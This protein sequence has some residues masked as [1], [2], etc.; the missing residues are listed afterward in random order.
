MSLT[1]VSAR[2]TI[3]LLCARILADPL[4]NG[5]SRLTHPDRRLSSRTRVGEC[6]NSPVLLNGTTLLRSMSDC[7]SLATFLLARSSERRRPHGS[8]SQGR[9]FDFPNTTAVAAHGN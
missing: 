9:L 1:S 5:G 6:Q 4:S 7:W 2:V 8:S 3:L